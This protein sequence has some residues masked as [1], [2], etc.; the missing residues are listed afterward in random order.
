MSPGWALEWTHG[1][2][3]TLERTL[4]IKHSARH[5]THQ[6]AIAVMGSTEDKGT[7]SGTD[8]TG[9]GR[10]E[11]AE[12]SGLDG[13]GLGMPAPRTDIS[14]VLQAGW[15]SHSPR[16]HLMASCAT[17]ITTQNTGVATVAAGDSGVAAIL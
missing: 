17:F 10:L 9:T 12:A 8:S 11:T 4:E 1:L 16:N 13:A 14:S 7:T 3:W 6:M 15:Q 5:Q 2:K